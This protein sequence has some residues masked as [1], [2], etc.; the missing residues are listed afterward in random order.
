MAAVTQHPAF[1]AHLG[2][3]GFSFVMDAAL[4]LKL[5][6]AE[7]FGAE[8]DDDDCSYGDDGV[9]GP[10]T[11]GVLAVLD[12]DDDEHVSAAVPRPSSA[13]PSSAACKSDNLDLLNPESELIDPTPDVHALFLEYDKMFF[14][15]HLASVELR[16]SPRMTLCAGLCVYQGKHGGCSM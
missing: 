13:A 2:C 5:Q 16:W 4:A 6:L 8:V 7:Y 14:D 15:G 10:S 12:S 3:D 11:S 1:Q 9:I